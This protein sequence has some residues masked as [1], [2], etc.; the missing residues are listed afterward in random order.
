MQRAADYYRDRLGFTVALSD[1]EPDHYGTA[2]RDNCH[3]D[4]AHVDGVTARPN[5]EVIPPDM[6]DVYFWPDDVDA[7]HAELY[8]RGATIIQRPSDQPYGLR[9]FRVE[10]P[11]GHVLAFGKRIN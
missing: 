4:F 5:H 3:V 11:D 1:D 6:F 10:D 2:Q 8:N 7:L 9:E